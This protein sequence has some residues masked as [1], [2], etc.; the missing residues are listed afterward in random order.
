MKPQKSSKKQSTIINEKY[1]FFALSLKCVIY[2]KDK[3]AGITTK[4]VYAVAAILVLY[5]H[6]NENTHLSIEK[7]A[8]EANV[9]KNFLEQILSYH[10]LF[11]GVVNLV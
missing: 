9:P 2:L 8:K 10:T 1:N 4:G 7:I 11:L 3:N 6:A 5:Q